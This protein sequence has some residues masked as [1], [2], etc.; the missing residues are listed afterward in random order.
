MVGGNFSSTANA[1]I[2]CIEQTINAR[3][4]V[5]YSD[6]RRLPNIE[7]DVN[8]GR[9]DHTIYIMHSLST[10]LPVTPTPPFFFR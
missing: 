10:P 3:E 7:E 2:I 1:S 6:C 4:I 5:P 8:E 9:T